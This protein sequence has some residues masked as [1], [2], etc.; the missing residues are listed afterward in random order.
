MV[1]I[2]ES[3]RAK[4]SPDKA[5]V[6]W[7]PKSPFQALISSPS[8]R[9]K[10]QDIQ[11][12]VRN[13]TPSPSPRKETLGSQKQPS[14]LS[15]PSDD[16]EAEEEDEEALRLKLEILEAKLKLKQLEKKKKLQDDSSQDTSG[17][18]FHP[19]ADAQSSSSPTRKTR[20]LSTQPDLQPPAVLVPVSPTR[21]Q[22]ATK[23]AVSPARLRLGLN[24][25]ARA[26]EVSLKRAR[27]GTHKQQPVSQLA[28]KARTAAGEER[29][30]SSF[31]QRLAQAQRAQQD[32]QTKTER[33]EKAR[34]KGFD[35]AAAAPRK[36]LSA[37]ALNPDQNAHNKRLSSPSKTKSDQRRTSPSRPRRHGA[38]EANTHHDD[39]SSL[40][41]AGGEDCEPSFYDAFSELHLSKR[42]ISHSDVARS[43]Q[44]SEIY[45]IP[46][47]LKEVKSP[48]YEPP[49]CESDFVVFGILASKTSPFDQK[50]THRIHSENEPKDYETGPKNKFMVLRLCDLK[51]EIDCF[52]FGT[53]F[54]QFWKLTEGT[55]L[56]ILNPGILPPKGNQHNGRFSLKL[57]SSEDRVMEIGLARD[58]GYCSALRKDG[59]PCNAW[60]D[61]RKTEV[62]E[63][64]VNLQIDKSRKGRME[65]NAMWR[66]HGHTDS[67]ERNQRKQKKSG[68]AASHREYG[69]LYSVN[70]G[71]GSSAAT[72]LDADDTDALH[73]M[74]REEASRKRIAAAQR[75]RDVAKKLSEA[76]HG[77]G[78][79]YLRATL[80]ASDKST[81]SSTRRRASPAND[82]DAFFS[83]PSAADLG[84]LGK[85]ASE[86]RLS[87]AKDRKRQFGVGA[88]SSAGS[89]AMGWGGARNPGLLRPKES[90]L[91]SPERAQRKLDLQSKRSA[92]CLR[93]RDGSLSPKKKARFALE[94]GIREPGRESLGDDLRSPLRARDAFDEHDDDLD[95]V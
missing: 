33:I 64:H 24:A 35:M 46:R 91:G 39:N 58:L 95:I 14:T 15:V 6:Q 8:G 9:K 12:N 30:A 68:P 25:A 10:W 27:D 72:L 7:P 17:P 83:K 63:F 87:P 52:L 43:L 11:G 54:D 16:D 4:V 82:A 67:G 59:Q 62:C 48:D 1:F 79:E 38:D 26:H 74:T 93:S 70:T 22:F 57:A 45:P 53:A 29:P 55:L 65:V 60:V 13:R 44:G 81:P 89:T 21:K 32:K 56:A 37:V 90:R 19:K 5:Q 49:D 61:K 94:K 66:G 78:A 34:S 18:C 3:P 2:R 75:E 28:S 73:N 36:S 77:V 80:R 71:L 76:G 88:M 84:L 20:T 31:S 50:A 40:Q 85:K 69:Q 86:Q 41:I 51:W 42:H 23:E 47:L 92:T